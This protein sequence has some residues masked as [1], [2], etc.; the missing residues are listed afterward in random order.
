MVVNVLRLTHVLVCTDLQAHN[1]SQVSMVPM[2]PGNMQPDSHAAGKYFYRTF[3]RMESENKTD[4]LLH[5]LMLNS[6][7]VSGMV[8]NTKQYSL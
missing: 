5:S 7:A 4:K 6:C 8:Y 1:A 3:L 2:Q